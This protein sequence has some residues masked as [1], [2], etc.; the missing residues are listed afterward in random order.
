ML[1]ERQQLKITDVYRS[2]WVEGAEG[3]V[4]IQVLHTYPSELRTNKKEK[5][6][7]TTSTCA[8]LKGTPAHLL[9]DLSSAA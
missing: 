6:G 9:H 2:I 3:H 4:A 5:H 7:Q 8:K 1:S